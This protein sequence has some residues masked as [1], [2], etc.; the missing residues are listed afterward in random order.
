MARLVPD[1]RMG[2]S[3]DFLAQQTFLNVPSNQSGNAAMA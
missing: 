2:C 1:L 3:M